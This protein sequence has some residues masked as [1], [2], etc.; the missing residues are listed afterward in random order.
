MAVVVGQ[1]GPLRTGLEYFLMALPQIE[2]VSPADDASSAL[3]MI[4]E[5]SPAL[6]VLDG[7]R[8]NGEALAALRWIRS[9]CPQSCL[10]FMTDSA[11]QQRD[12]MATGADAAFVI[13][14]PPAKLF[15]VVEGLLPART[16]EQKRGNGQ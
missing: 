16:A 3:R 10:L 4:G 15:E 11:Q 7:T 1:P 6:I 8:S 5:H 14:F 13:G 2:A 12:A 9:E